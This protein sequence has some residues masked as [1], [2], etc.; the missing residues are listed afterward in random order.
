MKDTKITN[1]NPLPDEV[2]VN[3]NMF[4]ALMLDWIGGHVDGA[5]VIAIHQCG[6]AEGVVQLLQE[7]TQPGSLGDTINHCAILSFCT[8]SG[9]G[10]LTLGGPGHEIV[11]E[12]HS[13]ARCGLAHIRTSS[14]I[15]ISVYHKI[16]RSRRAQQKT[17]V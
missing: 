4:G 15:S 16:S 3:L 11:P 8:R 6:L 10:V 14:P 7:L 9:D 1:G 17:K 5:D 12:E 2:E 13:I